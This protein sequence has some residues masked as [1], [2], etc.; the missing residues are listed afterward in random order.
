MK[1]HTQ[2]L[3]EILACMLISASL[4][5]QTPSS[6][7]ILNIWLPYQLEDGSTAFQTTEYDLLQTTNAEEVFSIDY[8]NPEEVVMSVFA[9]KTSNEAYSD[10]F[11]YYQRAKG[12]I[13]LD[14]DTINVDDQR[15][16][17]AEYLHPNN[18]QEY[19]MCFSLFMDNP[20]NF[21]VQGFWNRDE[22]HG[23]GDFLNYEI[24]T[25][26]IDRIKEL[27]EY[28]FDKV[29]SISDLKSQEDIP[30]IPSKYV[31]SIQYANQT[32]EMEWV[33]NDLDNSRIEMNAKT[34][35]TEL[36]VSSDIESK[37]IE[38]GE[39]LKSSTLEYINMYDCD[40]HIY[41]ENKML[42]QFYIADGQWSSVENEIN[43][44]KSTMTTMED[45]SFYLSRN[46]LVAANGAGES[47][48]ERTILHGKMPKD[49]SNFDLLQLDLN[50]KGKLKLELETPNGTY[51]SSFREFDDATFV[52]WD[53]SSFTSNQEDLNSFDNI[54]AIRFIA[55][56]VDEIEISDVQFSKTS[57][58]TH[59]VVKNELEINVFPN[60]NNG[61]FQ[62]NG[63]E[64][65]ETALVQVLSANGQLV[66]E[67]IHDFNADE[68][69]QLNL[70]LLDG[71]YYVLIHSPKGKKS[72]KVHVF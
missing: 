16:L 10:Y 6:T 72:Q 14:I 15:M 53:P 59:Q 57:T 32:L 69:L 55:E 23:F 7:D 60:P 68:S 25:S 20:D 37:E 2:T 64:I 17:V 33:N 4:F 27:L 13:L 34:R 31:S 48:I 9:S 44:L 8:H 43:V 11:H 39:D 63:E 28:M 5:A 54:L 46:I 52:E 12:S 47:V 1:I 35:D 21:F 58:A 36:S 67:T 50:G 38:L 49:L 62:I 19:V 24:H 61:V 29:E 56:H 30:T 42:D 51:N 70:N 22:Y 65:N 3:F 41:Q 40:L 66:H 45:K 71:L 26:D 18:Q